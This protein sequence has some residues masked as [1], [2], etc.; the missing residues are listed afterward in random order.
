MCTNS[1]RSGASKLPDV[2]VVPVGNGTLLLGAALAVD[3]LS[4]HGLITERP[5]LYA[6]QAEAVSPLA[7]AFR[8][9]ADD[10]VDADHLAGADHPTGADHLAGA[11]GPAGADRPAAT[12]LAE[13]IAIPRP[14]RARQILA[15][16]RKS[17]GTFLTV[18][19]DQIRSAQRDLAARGL[20][21]ESTGVACWAAVAAGGVTGGRSV[22]VPLCGAGA[23]T[24]MAPAPQM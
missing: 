4:A 7:T 21:V 18:T 12:T 15:A 9:G 17:G 6:V 2:I 20:Y 22:V 10:L 19:E 23:K 24:G 5:A 13:G 3:E 1:G 11:D 16:V 8:A 14:P